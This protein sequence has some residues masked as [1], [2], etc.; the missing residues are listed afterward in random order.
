MYFLTSLALAGWGSFTLS[1]FHAPL[2]TSA[3]ANIFVWPVSVE[4]ASDF[5]DLSN[6]FLSNQLAAIPLIREAPVDLQGALANDFEVAQQTPYSTGRNEILSVSRSSG[7]EQLYEV[8][9]PDSG[10]FQLYE[11]GFNKVSVENSNAVV[12]DPQTLSEA[13]IRENL[14]A[15]SVRYDNNVPVV[16]TLADG[17]KAEFS[18]GQIVVRSPNGQVVETLA[19]ETAAIRTDER[20]VK[21][22]S[23]PSADAF[24]LSEPS[25][26]KPPI[27]QQ[28]IAQQIIA[29]QASSSC[30]QTIRSKFYDMSV[31]VSTGAKAMEQAE[32]DYGKLINWVLTFS[33]KSLEDSTS[34]NSRNLTFQSVACQPPVQ[35]NE[36]QTY[37]GASEIRT[38]LFRLPKGLNQLV[39]LEYEFY[40]IP[41]RMELYY[42][43]QMIFEVGPTAGT[44]RVQITTLP[45]DAAYVG[46]KLI[47]NTNVDTRWWY[48]IFCDSELEQP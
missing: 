36:A 25:L 46:V 1:V 22:L 16:A 19:M 47:G 10:E 14:A 29:Q 21:S 42:D 23:I 34:P 8:S 6:K 45:D 26:S 3:L 15:F 32:S 40:V 5:L 4:P 48:T 18:A 37:E 43:G 9:L 12:S 35:C 30:E 28:I 24:S 13:Q 44:N 33:A 27:A 39:T 31:A 11:S 20:V 38:D 41:D 2:L 17:A 7:T